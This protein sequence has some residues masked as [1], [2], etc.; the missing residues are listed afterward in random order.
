VSE[1]IPAGYETG[2]LKPKGIASLLIVTN[3][4]Q[5]TVVRRSLRALAIVPAFVLAIGA[6]PAFA[7]PP[8]SWPPTDNGSTLHALLL[9]VGAPL[10]LF[11]GITLL[12]SLP[13]MIAGHKYDSA[14]A[15]RDQPEWFGGPRKGVDAAPDDAGA[16]QG[17][18][19]TSANW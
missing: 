6:A 2:S 15:F 8:E 13:S 1:I 19:G 14:L 18:G 16:H 7:T 3:H 17:R 9:L 12:V 11:V 4:M 5:P 10:L